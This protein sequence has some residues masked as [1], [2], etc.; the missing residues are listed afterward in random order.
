[1]RFV[2]DPRLSLALCLP[3]LQEQKSTCAA[4]VIYK[5]EHGETNTIDV[6]GNFNNSFGRLRYNCVY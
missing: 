1:M 2:P 4:K 3:T 5:G 6:F